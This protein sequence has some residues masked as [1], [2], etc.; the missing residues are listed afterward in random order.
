MPT[1][2]KIALRRI[3]AELTTNPLKP[4]EFRHIPKMAPFCL[5]R[6][7]ARGDLR[8]MFQIELDGA[9]YYIFY[10]PAPIGNM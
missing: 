6:E 8:Y 3:K 1:I 9:T 2:T 5:S 10:S 7:P 4:G